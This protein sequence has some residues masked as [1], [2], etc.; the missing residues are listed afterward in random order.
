M[1][2]RAVSHSLLGCI[3][4]GSFFGAMELGAQEPAPNK[5]A[6]PLQKSDPAPKLDANQDGSQKPDAQTKLKMAKQELEAPSAAVEEDTLKK[7]F[8]TKPKKPAQLRTTP[9]ANAPINQGEQ[10]TADHP[11]TGDSSDTDGAP[12]FFTFERAPWRD[13][14]KWLS[15]ECDLAL[16]FEELPT[17]S[18]SYTDPRGFDERGA[19]DRL[20][21]FLLPQGYTLVRSG[22][23]LS[24]INLGDPRS[25]QQL[26]VLAELVGVE[27]L[28]DRQPHEVVKC[29]FPL[30]ELGTEDAIE[31]L[32]PLNL[33]TTPASFSRTNQL[34]ITDT[35]A[36]LRS[37]KQIIDSFNPT[38]LDNGTVM[39]NFALQHVAAEDI[40]VVARPHLGLA[41]GEMIGIDVSL[42]AD[43]QGE[44]IFVTGVEDKVRLIESLITA[45]DKPAESLAAEG[46]DA[47]LRSHVVESGNV[48][49]VY[50]VLQT[51]L[52]GESMRLSMDEESR[53]IVA[54]AAPAIQQE[55]EQTIAQLQATEAEFE[56][57]PLK[58]VDPYLVI[59]LLEEMLDLP[60]A[61]DDPDDIDPD[62]PKI[63]ADPG[64]MRLFVRAKRHDIEQ[65]KQIVEGLDVGQTLG[66]QDEMR[67]L[68][69]SGNRV[70]QLLETAAKFWRR[71]N[72]VIFY[73]AEPTDEP[74][75]TERAINQD[76]RRPKLTSIITSDSDGAAPRLLAGDRVTQAPVIRCQMTP[77]G[78]LL[79]S[80]DTQALTSFEEHLRTIAGPMGSA[81]SPPIVFYLK[82][83][84]PQDAL[85][86]LSELLDGGESAKEAV[87][88]SLINGYVS[89]TDSLFGSMVTSREGMTT[90]LADTITIVADPRL[91]RLIAQGTA[92]D[93]EVI[94]NYLEIIDK[95]KGITSVETYGTTHV[96]E[97]QY[98]DAAEVATSLR[99]AYAG[100]VQSGG[101]TSGGSAAGQAGRAPPEKGDERE[102][103]DK[104][105][106][107]KNGNAKAPGQPPRD[108]EPKMTIA[109]HAPSN[110][111][112]VTAPEELFREVEELAKTIDLRS[113]QTVEI[114]SSAN[115]ALLQSMFQ[116]AASSNRSP[117]RSS[118]GDDGG[119]NNSSSSQPSM[120]ELLRSK[121]GR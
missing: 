71:P 52:S 56:V 73:P 116:P 111:L 77:R 30:G 60:D 28:V 93:I 20:N 51:L 46:S 70:K 26:N 42:S 36:K 96:I 50:N 63:D 1:I 14:I 83:V 27:Q 55:I 6:E 11:D 81:P 99:E 31:E 88:G 35:V 98:T 24:V 92:S 115:A 95:D 2:R 114:V 110:S 101:A 104:A 59:S 33:M 91:N 75:P 54:L 45:L 85:R 57:I 53:S 82:Y 15:L 13:V 103:A 9:S 49:T 120:A 72:P 74:K 23:L 86:M 40:L 66:S 79:Q 43:L 87:A 39:R 8:K 44:N 21:L 108:L 105:D 41:T 65:I 90:L 5:T 32:A 4:L 18:F 113:Q 47:E 84:K 100:R 76:S 29:M 78:L 7:L 89:S 94:E 102:K 19:I 106:S 3:I 38:T 58:S 107:K 10:S 68:P 67:L 117:S 16:H 121:L 22:R 17:G 97:L 112:I 12:L 37:V 48:E 62:A 34:M 25:V 69:M 61:L 64:N 118:R 119:R 109:V 80:N